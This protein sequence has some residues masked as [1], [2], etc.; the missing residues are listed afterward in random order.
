MEPQAVLSEAKEVSLSSLGSE[1]LRFFAS[2]RMTLSNS[3]SSNRSQCEE[4]SI[5]Y[6][7]RE[8]VRGH[9]LNHFTLGE[10]AKGRQGEG[11]LVP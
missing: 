9:G 2:L 1:L 11:R 3:S 5:H 10:R 4:G 7:P 8:R 6:K